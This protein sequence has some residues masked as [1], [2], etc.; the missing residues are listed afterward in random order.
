[1]P[2]DKVRVH[3]EIFNL[4]YN[5]NGGFT[6]DEVYEMPV[7]LRYFYLKLLVRRRE[8]EEEEMKN[9]QSSSPANQPKQPAR[10]AIPRR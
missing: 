2:N 6:H 9:S 3:E 10:P 1:M 4:I 5:A 8:Q 7:Y